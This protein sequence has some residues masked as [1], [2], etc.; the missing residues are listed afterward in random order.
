VPPTPGDTPRVT[1][2]EL[3]RGLAPITVGLVLATGWL[4][5]RG[6]PVGWIAYAISA[7]TT[8]LV[9]FTR[10]NPL[11][12]FLGA[13][14]LGLLGVVQSRPHRGLCRLTCRVQ[15]STPNIRGAT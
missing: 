10:V 11:W 5:A 3:Y 14:L 8:A 6:A 4:V 12:L 7:V 9:L 13:G 15:L 1:L 2:G